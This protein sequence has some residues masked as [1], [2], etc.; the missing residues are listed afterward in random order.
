M[1]PSVAD[2][3]RHDL[4]ALRAF[5]MLLGLALHAALSFVPG[6]WVVQD[7]RPSP[8][9]GLFVAAVHGFRMPLFFLLSG[10]FT[11]M[12]LRR[13]GG[14]GLLRQR[15]TRILVPCLLGAATIVPLQ[16]AIGAWA[17]RAPG[18]SEPPDATTLVGAIR[19]GDLAAIRARLD[20]G[21]DPNAPDGATGITPLVWAATLG[22]A[23]A[24]ALLLDRGADAKGRNR[25]GNTAMHGAAFLGRVE[26]VEELLRRGADPLARN[27]D[28]GTPL[29]STRTDPET[30]RFIA[31]FLGIDVGDG[32]DLERRRAEV[33]RRLEPLAPAGAA[34]RPLRPGGG[35]RAAYGQFLASDAFRVRVG[36]RTLDLFTTPTFDHL[37]F[38][39][40]LC[41][42]VPLYA[43]AAWGAGR[44]PWRIAPRRAMAALVPLALVPQAFMGV[45]A[46]TF[47]PDTSAGLLPM[48][49]L[50]LYYGIFFAFG[51][52]DY[53]AGDA[54][55]RVA[56]RWRWLLALGLLAFPF[57]LATMVGGNRLVG[58]AAQVAYAWSLSL[59]LMGLFRRLLSRPSRAVRYLSDASYFLYLFHLP[60]LIAAQALVRDWPW[61]SPLKFLALVVGVAVPLLVVY[62]VAVRYHAPGRLLN[63]P[64]SRPSRR[65]DA[66]ASVPALDAAE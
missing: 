27:A 24:A 4:D 22:D 15:A 46:P 7:A 54:A 31:G 5:A 3:R 17:W 51:A 49:H 43:L 26:L 30:T 6:A 60:L 45:G 14:R 61:P 57:G 34:D 37:W 33:R 63:G 23:R 44:L 2:D 39:W 36:G 42:L 16:H 64:R 28:G 52:L 1:S 66:S 25:D 41:W 58:G 20:A 13:R 35:L 18:G 10:F 11:A 62:D 9:F 21:A 19:G 47:G 38:L 55:G 50:L 56:R 48:P 65:P 53:D 59:G 29:G 8:G 32:R 12:V 40:F